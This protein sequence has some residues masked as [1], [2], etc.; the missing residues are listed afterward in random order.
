MKSC[1][2]KLDAFA[3]RTATTPVLGVLSAFMKDWIPLIDEY[4][5]C[6]PFFF[7]DFSHPLTAII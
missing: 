7:R 2:P 3:N 1:R 5:Y 6:A 4:H